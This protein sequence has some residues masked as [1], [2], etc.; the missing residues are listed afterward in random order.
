MSSDS[1][2]KA[3]SRSDPSDWLEEHGDA[4]FRY[5]M[6]H[7]GDRTAAEDAVQETLL[8]ALSARRDFAGQSSE[9]TWLVG[10]LKHKVIDHIRK[11]S[12]EQAVVD[13]ESTE[14]FVSEC[15]NEKGY[16]NAGP[17]NWGG[18]ATGQ[19]EKQEF[20]DVFRFCVSRLPPLLAGAFMLRETGEVATEEIC[21]VLKVTA[22][23]LWTM[24]H[25]ARTRLRSCLEA[26]WF[27]REA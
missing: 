5:A 1:G 27:D 17:R 22:T 7:L 20:W 12:R 24:L 11:A 10:I 8:A 21:K 15:F 4:L 25:R 23:N 3:E 26:N 18:G 9:R 19:L 14:H 2:R 6:L 13:F 16:W